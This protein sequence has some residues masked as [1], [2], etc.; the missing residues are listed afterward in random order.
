MGGGG[1]KWV[2]SGYKLGGEGV[3]GRGGWNR[4]GKGVIGIGRGQIWVGE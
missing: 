3:K 1:V 2:G 4:L